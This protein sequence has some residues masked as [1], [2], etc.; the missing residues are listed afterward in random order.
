MKIIKQYIKRNVADETLLVPV[1]DS[2]KDFNGMITLRGIG[3]FIWDNI[4]NVSSFEALVTKIL[5]EYDIDEETAKS[6]SKEFI[7]CLLKAGM[8]AYTQ[9]NW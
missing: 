9:D 8:V 2:S 6:D 1:G 5:D 3:E 7:S 4:E